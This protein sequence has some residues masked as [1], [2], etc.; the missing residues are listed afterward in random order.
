MLRD[1]NPYYNIGPGDFIKEELEARGWLQTDFADIL[2]MSKKTINKLINN[3]QSITI[4]TA[5][6]LSKAFG[7]SPQY[8]INL[9]TNYRLRLEDNTLLEDSIEIKANIYKYMPINEMFKKDWIK[10]VE[11]VEKLKDV[12]K[13]FW[14]I[15]EV[16]FTFLDNQFLPNFRKSEAYQKFNQYYALTWFQMAKNCAKK[17][18][19]DTFNKNKLTSLSLRITEF[20]NM[21]NGVEIFLTE[22]NKCGIKFFVLSHLQKTYTD[23]ASF[24]DESNPTIIHTCRHDRIDNFWFTIAHEIGHILLHMNN[25]EQFFIDESNRITTD[26]EKEADVYALKIFKEDEILRFFNRTSTHIS[27]RSIITCSVMLKINEAII[28]GVLQHHKK[29]P[30]THLNK[31]KTNAS[32]YIPNKYFAENKSDS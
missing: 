16:D 12:V 31:F 24:F 9:D 2:G 19:V 1:Y 17:Y 15:K 10:S 20:S 3:K 5:K 32:N 6:L 22:L 30:I 4:D 18:H 21:E 26:E 29:L 23:G 14:G 8:W 11:T 7:Q 25:K 28:V 13:K 27:K